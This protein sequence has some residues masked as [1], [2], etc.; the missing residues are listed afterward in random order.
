MIKYVWMISGQMDSTNSQHV[1]TK[2]KGSKIVATCRRPSGHSHIACGE[3]VIGSLI[4][5]F[6]KS[7]GNHGLPHEI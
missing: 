1:L 2:L 5:G 6:G 7:I 4:T 3:A